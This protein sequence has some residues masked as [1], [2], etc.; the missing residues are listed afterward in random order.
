MQLVRPFRGLRPSRKLASRVASPPYD[1]LSRE[2]ALTM[3]RGN[4]QSFL[5]INK[6][7]IDVDPALDSHDP[8]VYAKGREN[9]D[10]FIESGVLARDDSESY[11]IY[12]QIMGD[13]IQTGIAAVASVAAYE[14][15]L[16]KKH[17]LTRPPKVRDRVEHMDALGAQVGPVFVTY[18][19]REL[20]D[21]LIAQATETK[22]E[23]D[24]TAADGIRHTFWVVQDPDRVGE[25]QRALDELPAL[26][27]ADG[28]HRSEAAAKLRQ[29]LRSRFPNAPSPA[30][31]DWFLVVLFPH[32]QI[33]ILDYNRVV[34]DLD[35]LSAMDFLKA[36]EREFLVTEV[37]A[38]AA[39]PAAPRDFALYL[40]G[41]WW[42]LR[43][44][45]GVLDALAD[46]PPSG[47]LDVALLHDRVFAPLLG[48]ADQRTDDRV[49]FVGGIRGLEELG[50]KVDSGDWRAAFAF[51]PT[52]MDDLIA[53]ADS[54]GVM[55]PKS[56]WFEPKL[57]S[58]LV[59]H[60]IG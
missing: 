49:D 11:Y 60:V 57:R 25:F 28:H 24:F 31:W 35:G 38:A 47:R 30:P 34:R 4:P 12:R 22:V 5:R 40:D 32:D 51:H 10:R 54:G 37:E 58:G 23:Y 46:K 59:S 14:Q 55:P 2:E 18:R 7:E 53:V 52:S 45:Q 50:R 39:K 1:V 16:V 15:G 21:A 41:A 42:R 27:V 17:E 26:Y 3:A 8:A 20:L 6:P 9:L 33:Q 56:T 48:I 29:T 43:P 19:A 36:L 13:H 44:R